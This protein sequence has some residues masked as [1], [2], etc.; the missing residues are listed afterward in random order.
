MNKQESD[1]NQY[2]S[3]AQHE[4]N[5]ELSLGES[6]ESR[7]QISDLEYS[8][9][10]AKK[11]TSDMAEEIEKAN[12]EV[13][14]LE[15]DMNERYEKWERRRYYS[16]KSRLNKIRKIRRSVWLYVFLYI[17]SFAIAWLVLYF[18]FGYKDFSS[19][20]R[21]EIIINQI[22]AFAVPT[23]I[24]VFFNMAMYLYEIS[25]ESDIAGY[26]RNTIQKTADD[27]IYESSIRMSYKYLD[28]YYLQTREQAG[29]G[30]LITL[31]V[32]IVGALI[33]GVGIIA[34]FLGVVEP[35]YI[36]TACGVIIEFIASV[37][38]YLYNKTVQS[39]GD[40][41]NKL[42]LSQNI[43]IALKIS[44]SI[45][46]SCKDSVKADMVKELLKDV[47]QHINDNK[48]KE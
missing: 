38:F 6:E 22:V 47:N 44:E 3:T 25:L 23:V 40:Y 7:K 28:Q 14:E 39:M 8:V 17:C 24:A 15:M 41:H 36:T 16:N 4:E 19:W 12:R 29:K 13:A 27:D 48:M 33:I 34:M 5:A 26:E 20:N 31:S 42:V 30:F 18:S 21:E 1:R 2:E 37:F 46:G 9:K 35:A 11:E 32:A 45:D 43:A 10:E